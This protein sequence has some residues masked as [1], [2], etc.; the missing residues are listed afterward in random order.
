MLCALNFIPQSLTG[1]ISP[2]DWE[3]PLAY[4]LR[5]QKIVLVP[6]GRKA[7]WSVVDIFKCISHELPCDHLCPN[8]KSMYFRLNTDSDF[9]ALT[10]YISLF[11]SPKIAEV[12]ISLPSSNPQIPSLP[13]LPIRYSE[14][15][16]LYFGDLEC[17]GGTFSCSVSSRIVS[18]LNKIESLGCDQLDAVAMEHISQLS[19]L[20]T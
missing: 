20:R 4:A 18:L 12:T 2:A 1:P 3:V 6:L 7:F 16:S 14:L 13:D 10:S 17:A 11:R 9:W 19:H 5:I 8:L 15:T